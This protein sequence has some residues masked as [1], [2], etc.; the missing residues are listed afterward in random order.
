[1]IILQSQLRNIQVELSGGLKGN[2]TWELLNN[3]LNLINA[4]RTDILALYNAIITPTPT[5]AIY[6]VQN[7]S[8][9]TGGT[10]VSNG[11]TMLALAPSGTLATL[12]VQFPPTPIN[13]QLFNINS[14][15]NITDLTLT[16][17]TIQFYTGAF[18]FAAGV[19]HYIYN[20]S[21]AQWL[22]N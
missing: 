10:V 12:T 11:S 9:T 7:S 6:T 21:Q 20:S 1:M 8:P 15:E 5:Q 14:T 3:T 4:E 16:G 22:V 13:G 19:A 18:Y 17:G 2:A